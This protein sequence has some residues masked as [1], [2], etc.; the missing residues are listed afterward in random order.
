MATLDQSA[1][2]VQEALQTTPDAA[3]L[4]HEYGYRPERESGIE[5]RFAV[6]NGFLGGVPL[7]RSAGALWGILVAH[8]ELGLLAADVCGGP[9]RYPEHTATSPGA[10][11]WAR[12]AENSPASGRKAATAPIRR[13]A[14]SSPHPRYAARAA[15]HRLAPPRCAGR[16]AHVR[17]M[18]LSRSLIARLG[19]K[20]SNYRSISR[21]TSRL[22]P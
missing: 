1:R 2:S 21:P 8:L 16:I 7:G 14:R 12:L 4:L 18:R 6:S 11:A 5:S 10:R 9:V 15:A 19:C 13:V 20:W 3:W 22:K 17:S